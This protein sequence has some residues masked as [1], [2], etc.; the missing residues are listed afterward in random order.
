MG[1]LNTVPMKINGVEGASGQMKVSGGPGAVET[2]KTPGGISHG[3]M[4]MHENLDPTVIDLIA[5][6][7]AVFG[8]TVGVL[9]DWTFKDGKAVAITEYQTSDAGAKTKCLCR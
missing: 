1:E 3:N 8:F 5:V 4:Y 9:A 7:H 2:W 6:P